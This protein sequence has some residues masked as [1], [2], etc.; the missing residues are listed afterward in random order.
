MRQRAVSAAA[1]FS[2]SIATACLLTAVIEGQTGPVLGFVAAAT[3]AAA[4][5]REA[6][7]DRREQAVLRLC[8]RG[9]VVGSALD[10]VGEP[11]WRAVGVT[12][13]L[14]CLARSGQRQAIWRDGVSPDGFRR[15]AAYGLW[16]RSALPDPD[17]SSELIARKTVTGEQ[18]VPRTG[19]PR[20]R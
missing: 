1:A 7:R 9:V 16:R 20:G 4:L 13:N 6:T 10:G 18:S 5:V 17:D 19:R 14:I 2:G 15:I 8:P 12:R 3:V 11:R